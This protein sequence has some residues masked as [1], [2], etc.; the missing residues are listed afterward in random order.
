MSHRIA[1]PIFFFGTS[2]RKWAVYGGKEKVLYPNLHSG[3][4]LGNTVLNC[5][6]QIIVFPYVARA[7]CI[8]TPN[9]YPVPI[10][11]QIL[12]LQT[13][14]PFLLFPLPLVYICR[15]QFCFRTIQRLAK[16]KTVPKQIRFS[17]LIF[18]R[19]SK[20]P[21]AA[22]EI[23]VKSVLFAFC[24][25]SA[26]LNAGTPPRGTF[27]GAADRRLQDFRRQSVPISPPFRMS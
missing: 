24:F 6:A 23:E 5:S 9:L 20:C 7:Q 14:H 13:G 2:K 15:K 25:T 4:S 22:A 11:Y 8:Q 17:T 3:A 1:P 21:S 26:P 10:E 16:R 18:N 27:T 12:V 19:I